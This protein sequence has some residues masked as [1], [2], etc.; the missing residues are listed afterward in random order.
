MSNLF[1]FKNQFR[2]YDVDGVILD[3][4]NDFL[5]IREPVGFDGVD[6]T[7][8]R[9]DDTHG[10]FYEFSGAETTLGFDRVTFETS[11]DVFEPFSPYE[12]IK[13]V[14]GAVGVD[15]RLIFRF[16][17]FDVP[18]NDFVLQYEGDIDL[19]FSSILD[20]KIDSNVK[21]I[22]LGDLFKTRK[23]VPVN[24]N[25]KKTID[26]DVI[27]G[28]NPV[29]MFL[30][31]KVINQKQFAT[32]RTSNSGIGDGFIELSDADSWV[33]QMDYR[34]ETFG[35]P[36]QKLTGYK[37][38]IS[39]LYGT[40]VNTILHEKSDLNFILD[41]YVFEAT[42]QLVIDYVADYRL[43]LVNL[44]G[45]T[46]EYLGSFV[47][48]NGV[49]TQIN[50][51][52]TFPSISANDSLPITFSYSDTLSIPKGG[53][54]AI[55]DLW[56][57]PTSGVV[58]QEYK[59]IIDNTGD[60][61]LDLSF[62]SLIDNSTAQ[63][64]DPTDA[65]E[66]VLQVITNQSNIFLSDF[67]FNFGDVIKLTNGYKIRGNES[68]NVI[69]SF[70]DLFDNWAKPMFGLG[71]AIWETTPNIFKIKM[72]RY[73]F[74]YQDV[75][76]DFF[77][78]VIDGSFILEIDKDLISNEFV[79]GYKDFPRS[80]DENKENNID[81]FNT[82]QNLLTPVKSVKKKTEYISTA[83]GSG[84]KIENQR[85]E[86]FKDVPSD[87]VSDDDNLFCIDS[88][89][90]NLYTLEDMFGTGIEN[91][92]ADASNNTLS[93]FGGY[94]DI[95]V[96]DTIVLDKVSGSQSIE[97]SYD[98][99]AVEVIGNRTLYNCANFVSS[100]S[101]D[102]KWT[103]TLPE[104][105]LRAARDENFD[106]ITDVI[107]PSTIYNAGLN[108]K[109]MIKNHALIFNSGFNPKPDTDI[110][111]TQDAKLNDAM[112]CRFSVVQGLYN[113]D[114]QTTVEMGGDMALMDVQGYSKLFS[115]VIIKFKTNIGYDR[116]L[117][118]RDA[119]L[120]QSTNSDNFGYIRVKDYEGNEH[121]GFL[122]TMTYNPLPQQVEFTLRGRF[123]PTGSSFDYP[124]D[125]GMN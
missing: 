119:M 89:D 50:A 69:K 78:T 22:T 59:I 28:I 90:N 39:T 112:T 46:I 15:G 6:I 24:F 73:E 21:R 23:D 102:R 87:T 44:G 80:T 20:Y 7:L 85:R 29:D 75:E 12:L 64:Y 82:V 33:L 16:Y 57:I 31:S 122:Q 86:Q 91:V 108:P 49:S 93:I 32:S 48:I 117:A 26:G 125:A 56:D 35:F 52:I 72:E 118:I 70:K 1:E 8:S 121:T 53:T 3:N 84:Y 38:Q 101:D 2:I 40:G 27:S 66:Q 61:T 25:A 58:T 71:Y 115:G 10:V 83:I 81:E 30:H 11:Q 79:V 63:I 9:D 110:I 103:I 100:G 14:L 42:G 96:G 124:L 55:Y 94:F 36:A 17:N 47:D 114:P 60:H 68:R 88:V 65:F 67:F 45:S 43:N 99:E 120:N 37:N 98:I 104:S 54:F 92:I 51:P 123:V 76:I 4:P 113:K 18:L 19:E 106:L 116:V 13:G 95:R 5:I 111:T 41:T 62:D 107:S 97:G 105:R 77:E 74:F 109:Y 34:T